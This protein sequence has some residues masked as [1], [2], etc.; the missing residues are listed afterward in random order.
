M[1]KTCRNLLVSA[2][3]ASMWMGASVHAEVVSSHSLPAATLNTSETYA[4]EYGPRPAVV[5]GQATESL[6]AKQRAVASAK[7]RGI[8]GAQASR[9]YE[10]YLKSFEHPIPEAFETGVENK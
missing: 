9:S 8:D 7:P 2:A 4:E 5:I 3:V 10:R 6:L 1:T